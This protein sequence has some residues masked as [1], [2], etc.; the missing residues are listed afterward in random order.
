MDPHQKSID[1]YVLR[2]KYI[3]D[4]LIEALVPAPAQEALKTLRE[5]DFPVHLLFETKSFA[6]VYY[7]GVQVRI[8][9]PSMPVIPLKEDEM[10]LTREDA[11][12]FPDGEHFA[13]LLDA[14]ADMHGIMKDAKKDI[15]RRK[16][17]IHTMWDV[18]RVM[19]QLT[20]TVLKPT[21]FKVLMS[22]RPTKNPNADVLMD[23]TEAMT[24][25]RVALTLI[26]SQS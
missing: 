7:R 22:Y 18:Y 20:E 14:M 8:K 19:P 17:H 23:E 11:L 26:Q 2:T 13:A 15:L 10:V 12:K 16:R 3:D 4:H 5:E 24:Q 1:D 6:F 21:E 9:L 25:L